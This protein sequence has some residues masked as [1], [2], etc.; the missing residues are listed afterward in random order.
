MLIGT[1]L[2]VVVSA[3]ATVAAARYYPAAA[4]QE[5]Q[6]Q[7]AVTARFHARRLAAVKARVLVGT[8][9]AAGHGVEAPLAVQRPAVLAQLYQLSAAPGLYAIVAPKGTGKSTLMAQLSAKRPHIICA[10]LKQIALDFTGTKNIHST[11]QGDLVLSTEAGDMRFHK[12]VAYQEVD[13]RRQ[14]VD[15]RFKVQDREVSFDVGTYDRSRELIIDPVAFTAKLPNPSDPNALITDALNILYRVPL[16]DTLKA[17]IK[18]QILL[19]GQAQDYYWTNA[20]AAYISSPT[21]AN[22]QVVYT[23]LR[24]LYKY[25]MDLAE[26]QLC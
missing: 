21:A 14:I 18:T 5:Q 12:P 7:A 16:S 17:T 3:V 15:A 2:G 26:Y 10:D 23:R 1:L 11:R 4:K 13:G 6:S 22:Y 19:S 8:H 20:W 25:L 9:G 24:D